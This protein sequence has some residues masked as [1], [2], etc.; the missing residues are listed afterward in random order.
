MTEPYEVYVV[1]WTESIPDYEV[2]VDDII[3]SKSIKD[4]DNRYHKGEIK[5]FGSLFV[6]PFLRTKPVSSETSFGGGSLPLEVKQDGLG[7]ILCHPQTTF[8]CLV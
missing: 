7:S 3:H 6:I 1:K 2:R 8:L 4:F 5:V